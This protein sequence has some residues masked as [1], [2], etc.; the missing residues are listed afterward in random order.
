MV[1]ISSLGDKGRGRLLTGTKLYLNTGS[2]LCNCN[3]DVYCV[4]PKQFQLQRCGSGVL[5]TGRMRGSLLLPST[6]GARQFNC[7]IGFY[8]LIVSDFLLFLFL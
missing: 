6:V 1:V 4:F 7:V 2:K 3:S 8:F 5:K